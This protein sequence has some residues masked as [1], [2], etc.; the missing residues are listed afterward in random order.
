M[1]DP[2]GRRTAPDLTTARP[3]LAVHPR[4]ARPRSDVVVVR[5]STAAY[6]HS[7]PRRPEGKIS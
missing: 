1:V 4:R 3:E 5:H 6:A 2:V 7:H